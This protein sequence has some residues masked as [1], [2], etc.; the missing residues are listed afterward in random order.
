[1]PVLVWLRGDEP[2]FEEFSLDAETVMQQLGIKR[3]RLT[4]ISGTE[5][6]VGRTRIDRYVRPVYRPCDIADYQKWTRATA[7]H[8]KSSSLLEQA[9][10]KLEVSSRDFSEQLSDLHEQMDASFG[11]HL[12]RLHSQLG[13]S[14]RMALQQLAVVS[15]RR[16]Q[17][18]ERTHHLNIDKLN[19]RLGGIG[20]ELGAMQEAL[21]AVADYSPQLGEM[22]SALCYLQQALLHVQ[23]SQAEQEERLSAQLSVLRD[24]LLDLHEE[25]RAAKTPPPPRPER[26]LGRKP[27]GR[28]GGTFQRIERSPAP[29]FI[30]RPMGKKK[31]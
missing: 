5:L 21:A 12:N 15:E 4:Q 28:A 9:A 27:P 11:G 24:G 23:Q 31:P 3:S 26:C 1:L 22:H 7:T 25:L 6:R 30:P 2:Y 29:L 19:L 13:T 8:H 18:R 16:H 17:I 20:A 10:Q 14:L